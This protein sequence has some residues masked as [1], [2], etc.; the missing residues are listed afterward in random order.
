MHL[1][2][3]SLDLSLFTIIPL[4]LIGYQAAMITRFSRVI[5]SIE[6]SHVGKMSKNIT[7]C[8]Q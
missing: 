1:D 8:V 4:T 2:A 6:F 3:L 7:C 5:T